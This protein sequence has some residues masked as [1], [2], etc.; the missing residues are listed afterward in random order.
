VLCCAF[1]PHLR[2]PCCTLHLHL[3]NI[4]V[5]PNTV[6]VNPGPFFGL[7]FARRPSVLTTRHPQT[8]AAQTKRQQSNTV[9]NSPTYSATR[10]ANHTQHTRALVNLAPKERCDGGVGAWCAGKMFWGVSDSGIE[11]IG[12]TRSRCTL[13]SEGSWEFDSFGFTVFSFLF[14]TVYALRFHHLCS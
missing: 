11:T 4:L 3:N 6:Y 14:M 12:Q 9:K 5:M 7:R 2:F 1:I 13:L 8:Q 10:P